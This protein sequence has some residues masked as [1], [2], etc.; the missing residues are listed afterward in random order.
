MITSTVFAT[1]AITATAIAADAIGASELA[2]D[3]VAEIADAVWDEASTGHTDAGKAGQQLWTDLD[4]VLADTGELQTDWANGGR[5]DLLIDGV[6]TK[7]DYLPSAT[8]GQAGGV[9][10]AGSN[11]AT[12]FAT[13]TVTGALT[14]G[15]IVNNGVYTQTGAVTY[16]STIAAGAVTYSALTVTNALTTGS[17]V[18]NGVYTQTGAVTYASTIGAG[19]VT[20]ASMSVTGQFDCGNWLVDTTTVL[21]GAVTA[22]A[23]ITANIT[24]TVSTVTT[25]TNAPS[26]SSGVTALLGMTEVVP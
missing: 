26:D 7:T 2:A 14:T 10:I 20:Y 8:A 24:G 5:L 23:G 19:A 21:T 15:S 12:T 3:A 17:I 25:L 1:G 18:N 4:A 16:S 11:A 9:F 13:L 22:P 6:K